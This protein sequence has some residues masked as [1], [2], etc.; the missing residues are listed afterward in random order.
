ML[1]LSPPKAEESKG[2][3]VAAMKPRRLLD[4]FSGARAVRYYS[5]FGSSR[6]KPRETHPPL[7]PEKFSS[8]LSSAYRSAFCNPFAFNSIQEWVGWEVA[9]R[10]SPLACPP[11]RAASHSPLAP[12]P[13]SSNKAASPFVAFL[14]TVRCR[15][16]TV[17]YSVLLLSKLKAP[18]NQAEST[19]PKVL[20]LKQL[21]VPL[22]SIAFEKPGGWR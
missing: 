21:Q 7:A 16:T 5:H 3:V 9:F 19:L 18:L 22:E 20:I 8:F 11:W 12:D 1:I 17:S 13:A 2:S 6:A 14:F 4:P 10:I 15:L